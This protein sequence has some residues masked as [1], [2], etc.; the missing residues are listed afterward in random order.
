MSRPII[1]NVDQAKHDLVHNY[2]GGAAALAPMIKCKPNSLSNKVNPKM[3]EADLKVNEALALMAIT[4]NADLLKALAAELG[5]VALPLPPLDLRNTS[6]MEL[7]TC[8]SEW[9]AEYGQTAAAINEALAD[10]DISRQ[11][12]EKIKKEMHEDIAC[13]MELLR[14]LEALTI[15][16]K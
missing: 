8:W 7:L 5:Y 1:S 11:E 14:R 15:E 12:L 4:Q 13:Q 6:D 3:P 10:G 2:K 16:D 9:Q